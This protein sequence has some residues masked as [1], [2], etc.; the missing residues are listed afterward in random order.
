M[1]RLID[2]RSALLGA[3]LVVLPSAGCGREEVAKPTT[4]PSARAHPTA[5]R[6]GAATPSAE[7]QL[8]IASWQETQRTVAA[9][10]GRVVVLDLWSTW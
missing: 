3:C 6:P 1:R 4:E 8:S 10:Q 7:V 9:H 5:S 2:T